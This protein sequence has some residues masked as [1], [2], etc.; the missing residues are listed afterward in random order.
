MDGPLATEPVATGSNRYK[1]RLKN[2]FKM[3]PK[4]LKTMKI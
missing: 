3:H 1:V 2:T 4:T